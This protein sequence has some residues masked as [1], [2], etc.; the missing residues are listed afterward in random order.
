M[1]GVRSGEGGIH[2]LLLTDVPKCSVGTHRTVC[3]VSSLFFCWEN[4]CSTFSHHQTSVQQ[5]C[6]CICDISVS[7]CAL[8]KMGSI[9]LIALIAHHIPS[10][11]CSGTSYLNT[12][13]S[14]DRNLLFWEFPCPLRWNQTSSLN[15]T[16]VR[17]HSPAYNPWGYQF[18]KFIYRRNYIL[19]M[20]PTKHVL[21]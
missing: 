1:H 3:A 19:L 11:I 12:G 6:Q 4:S 15:I 17:S 13:F 18:P 10:I 16:C 20:C 21:L 5:W 2:D 7:I 9:I 14:A 8:K